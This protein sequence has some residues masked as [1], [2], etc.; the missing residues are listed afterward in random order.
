MF[1]LL[2][3][4][5]FRLEIVVHMLSFLINLIIVS[6]KNLVIL[7]VAIMAGLPNEQIKLKLR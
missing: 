2:D 5:V 3:Y 1:L 6:I 7:K 4:C